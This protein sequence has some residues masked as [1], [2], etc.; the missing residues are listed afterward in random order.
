MRAVQSGLVGAAIFVALASSLRTNSDAAWPGSRPHGLRRWGQTISSRRS[1]S[2][3]GR[4][5][6]SVAP[7]SRPASPTRARRRRPTSRRRAGL[8]RR[9]NTP[10]ID[11]TS[12]HV[13][14]STRGRRPIS[15]LFPSLHWRDWSY[16]NSAVDSVDFTYRVETAPDGTTSL[17]TFLSAPLLESE[18]ANSTRVTYPFQHLRTIQYRPF[19]MADPGGETILPDRSPLRHAYTY[20]I[21]WHPLSRQQSLTRFSLRRLFRPASSSTSILDI[22]FGGNGTSLIHPASIIVPGAIQ[23]EARALRDL[24]HPDNGARS[25]ARPTA[26]PRPARWRTDRAPANPMST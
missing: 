21:L 17:T 12:R 19:S 22:Q 24:I 26:C 13:G 4:R 11:C 8:D 18:F 25:P 9:V 16:Y 15:C 7:P 20:T 6:A 5:A 10:R 23:F 3:A 2:R 1:T 14:C